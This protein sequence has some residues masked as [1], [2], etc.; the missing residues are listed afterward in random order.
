MEWPYF[1]IRLMDLAIVFYMYDA[2]GHGLRSID[3]PDYVSDPPD[4]TS[5]GF[6]FHLIHLTMVSGP[7]DAWSYLNIRLMYLMMVP[8]CQMLL[9]MVSDP[10]DKLGHGFLLVRCN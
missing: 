6:R 10:S 7:P 9:T 2:S 3:V 5:D 8:I 1:H 4:A